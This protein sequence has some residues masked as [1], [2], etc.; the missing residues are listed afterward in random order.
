MPWS[1]PVKVHRAG[2]RSEGSTLDAAVGGQVPLL[3]ETSLSGH[4]D[5]P[6][7]K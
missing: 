4:R 1:F 2:L 6:V 3:H 7:K 5:S